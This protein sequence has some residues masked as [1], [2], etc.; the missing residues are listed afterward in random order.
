MRVL[1]TQENLLKGE[2]LNTIIK[3]QNPC[4]NKIPAG[5]RRLEKWRFSVIF[6]I[7]KTSYT[8]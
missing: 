4:I 6:V 7:L 1:T 5:N 8:A 3:L 2:L